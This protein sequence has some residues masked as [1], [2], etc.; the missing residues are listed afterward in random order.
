MD[1]SN[2]V[3]PKGEWVKFS[4]LLDFT[5]QQVRAWIGSQKIIDMQRDGMIITTSG[6]PQAFSF[7]TTSA[8]G[9]FQQGSTWGGGN[10]ITAGSNIVIDYA[11]TA[12]WRTT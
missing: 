2:T 11:R 6:S 4:Y 7:G 10:G 5:N 9:E 3:L 1:G 8:S 12:I